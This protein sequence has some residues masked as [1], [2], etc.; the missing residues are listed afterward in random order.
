MV[1]DVDMDV[2]DIDSKVIDIKL[3]GC[4]SVIPIVN[5]LGD[6]GK[7]RVVKITNSDLSIKRLRFLFRGYEGEVDF[8]SFDT[9]K[10]KDMS[11]M[12][13]NS[14][15]ENIDISNFNTE[16]LSDIRNM[17]YDCEVSN[18]KFPIMNNTEEM[19][20]LFSGCIVKGEIDISGLNTSKVDDMT[21]MFSDFKYKEKL[22][23][24]SFKTANVESMRRMF[25]G[26]YTDSLD[27]SCFI[28]KKVNDFSMMFTCCNIGELDIRSFNIN[29][30]ANKT[31]MF[32]FSRI[33][34]LIVN[35]DTKSRLLDKLERI[36]RGY[37]DEVVV[38]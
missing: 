11:Y 35:A 16:A 9:S 28:T 17:F 24:S 5:K 19:T 3:D 27:L 26:V 38:V 33:G 20:G 4:V 31:G 34:R 37:I 18:I 23:I 13:A 29:E 14:K 6:S 15:I 36:D 1:D 30:D 22:D 21:D 12:F 32:C 2:E 25:K 10:I 8:G 7:G